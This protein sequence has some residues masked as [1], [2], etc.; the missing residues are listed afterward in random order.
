METGNGAGVRSP[1]SGAVGRLA[2]PYILAAL[3]HVVIVVIDR[4]SLGILTPVP[5]A[6]DRTVLETGVDH[7]DLIIRSGDHAVVVILADD[8][9][10]YV[11]SDH[12]RRIEERIRAV[13]GSDLGADT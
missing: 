2:A 10:I 5:R 9:R 4:V 6:P 7:E 11:G 13:A 8:R 1:C 3:F 12:P